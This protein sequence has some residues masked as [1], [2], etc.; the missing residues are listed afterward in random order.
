MIRNDKEYRHSKEQRSKLEAELHKL[1]PA[2]RYSP[3]PY[4]GRAWRAP[5]AGFSEHDP[6][7][8]IHMC[9]PDERFV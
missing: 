4:A 3:R 8:M 9:G 7:R 6:H 1:S 2:R 5:T